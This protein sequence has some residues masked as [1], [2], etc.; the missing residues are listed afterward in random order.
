MLQIKISHEFQQVKNFFYKYEIIIEEDFMVQINISK[1]QGITQAIRD[2]IGAANIK[3]ADLGTWQKVMTEVNNAQSKNSSIFKTGNN[4]TSDVN[5]L[6][7]KSTYQ[8]NF[9]VDT[10]TVE[11]NDSIW[12]KITA[13]LTGEQTTAPAQAT[14]PNKPSG[15]TNTPS[16]PTAQNP[17][18]EK[19]ESGIKALEMRLLNR[20]VDGDKQQIAVVKQGGK[21]VRYA[22]NEDGNLGDTLAATRTFGKNKYISGNFPP[23]TRILEREVNGKKV[24][25]GVYED[26]NGNKVR[27][28]VTTGEDGKTTLGEELVTVSTMGKN[29]Y[30]TQTEMNNR[31]ARVF[32][33]GLPKG[34]TASYVSIDGEPTLIF[35]RDGKTL[36]QNQLRELAKSQTEKSE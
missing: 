13:L 8:S 6:G 34:V 1:G 36:N 4:Y 15:E 29:K 14:H 5:K 35:K 33:N 9:V 24:Q 20:S 25:I 3:N 28:L 19:P 17:G 22:V 10:G 32:P 18:T 21:K 31:I 7:D 26:E 30:I 2:K 11:I 23:K 12:S 27:K 16:T